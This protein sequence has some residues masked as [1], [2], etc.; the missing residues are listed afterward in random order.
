MNCAL[1]NKADAG[2]SDETVIETYQNRMSQVKCYY[3]LLIEN[4]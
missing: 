2:T 3:S 4:V 1:H